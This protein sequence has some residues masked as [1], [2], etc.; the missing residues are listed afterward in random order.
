MDEDL[1]SQGTP[2]SGARP[3]VTRCGA[4]KLAKGGVADVDQNTPTFLFREAGTM[5]L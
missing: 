4:M 2:E 3:R 1:R 5:R